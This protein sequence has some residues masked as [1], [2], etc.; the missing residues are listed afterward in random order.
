V[1]HQEDRDTDAR[2]RFVTIP[3]LQTILTGTCICRV[4]VGSVCRIVGHPRR[5][6]QYEYVS[7]ET[8]RQRCGVDQ[9]SLSLSRSLARSRSRSY[10]PSRGIEDSKIILP[11]HPAEVEDLGTCTCWYGILSLRTGNSTSRLLSGGTIGQ[12]QISFCL[13]FFQTAV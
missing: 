10:L 9:S 8:A 6:N 1:S 2:L 13:H 4:T 12:Q 11:M 7:E 5:P 3:E